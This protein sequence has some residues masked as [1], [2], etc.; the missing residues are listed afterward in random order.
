MTLQLW[1]KLIRCVV[2]KH[3]HLHFSSECVV[4]PWTKMLA[5]ISS[6]LFCRSNRVADENK[7]LKLLMPSA[8]IRACVIRQK[9][10]S[11]VQFIKTMC[12]KQDCLN[13]RDLFLL[14]YFYTKNPCLCHRS[15]FFFH[16][17]CPG[18]SSLAL[19]AEILKHYRT[20]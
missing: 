12:C 6:C 17:V 20:L 16:S 10:R 14:S 9:H 3:G 15:E 18:H 19:Q 7:T 8:K 5:I 1:V 11:W 2:Y 13:N 4:S